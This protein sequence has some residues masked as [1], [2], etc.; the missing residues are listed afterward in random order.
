MANKRV[1]IVDDDKIFLDELKETLDLSGY[2]MIAVNDAV[3]AVDTVCQTAP[4][5]ILVDLKMPQKS[6]FQV[7]HELMF[8]S[9]KIGD[10]PV[11]AMTGF[12]RDGYAALMNMCGIK[13]CL[14]KPFSPL[15]VIS[16]IEEALKPGYAKR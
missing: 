13:K 10:I 3:S 12:F 16:E 9:H 11:I 2:E 15:D 1:M 8:L 7:A 4:D 6:G 5:V 14:K